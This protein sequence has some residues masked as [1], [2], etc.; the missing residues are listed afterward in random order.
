MVKTSQ[1]NLSSEQSLVSR[2]QRESRQGHR[3]F[4][5]WFTGLSGSGKS[6][7][8]REVEKV[9]FHHTRNSYL[10][11]GDNIRRGLNQDLY[12]SSEDRCENIRRISE[13]TR[14]FLEAGVVVLTAFITPL[15]KYRNL[16]K[17][18]IGDSDYI[19]I[20]VRCSLQ[21]CEARDPKG[22]YKKAR[23]GEIQD[24]TGIDSPFEEPL[25]PSLVVDTNSESLEQSVEGVLAYLKDRGKI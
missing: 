25:A 7:L 21:T 1:R 22:L 13:V 6:S 17:S 20:Y 3:S 11:D 5:L 14:L 18:I 12:F 8:A 24:F 16:A 9:L 19:E 15:E 2:D 10:L 4:A 23:R